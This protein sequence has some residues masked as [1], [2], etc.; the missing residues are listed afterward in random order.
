M[1]VYSPALKEDSAN[2][3]AQKE[4]QWPRRKGGLLSP[5]LRRQAYLLV[6]MRIKDTLHISKCL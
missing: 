3:V 4:R 1:R 5:P 2:L 6:T